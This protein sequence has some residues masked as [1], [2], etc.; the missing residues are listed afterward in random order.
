MSGPGDRSHVIGADIPDIRDVPFRY[1]Q[2]MAFRHRGNVEEHQGNPILVDNRGRLTAVSDITK[3]AVIARPLL[4]ARAHV[5]ASYSWEIAIPSD[6][7]Y[8]RPISW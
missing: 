3:H 1:D 8:F 7:V 4:A 5:N 6:R 2:R